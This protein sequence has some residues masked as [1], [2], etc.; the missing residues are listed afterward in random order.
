[1]IAEGPSPPSPFPPP[2]AEAAASVFAP[3]ICRA[4]KS[5]VQCP[6][7]ERPTKRPPS[8]DLSCPNLLG[9]LPPQLYQ[10]VSGRVLGEEGCLKSSRYHV[11]SRC[12]YLSSH[13]LLP[14][15]DG[16]RFTDFGSMHLLEWKPNTSTFPSHTAKVR[17][18]RPSFRTSDRL[19]VTEFYCNGPQYRKGTER[20][21]TGWKS[22]DSLCDLSC[23]LDAELSVFHSSSHST[24]LRS[25]LRINLGSNPLSR[26]P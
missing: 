24:P 22:I 10:L 8:F 6:Q 15:P 2:S 18:G 25:L 20:Q 12:S 1:M 17:E 16:R 23:R 3:I 21:R 5:F 9:A 11:C 26:S 19:D 7:T 14:T 13:L 4:N